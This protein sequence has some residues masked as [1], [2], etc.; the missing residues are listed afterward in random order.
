MNL[1][2]QK[3]LPFIFLL[4]LFWGGLGIALSATANLGLGV[5]LAALA[6]A[7]FANGRKLNMPKGHRS[8][9]AFLA[10]ILI[11]FLVRGTGIEGQYF[12]TLFLAG[13]A[14]WLAFYNLEKAFGEKLINI[15]LGLGIAFGALFVWYL[16]SGYVPEGGWNLYLFST[17]YRNH[18]HIGDLWAVVLLLGISRLFIKRKVYFWGLMGLGLYFLFVSYSRSGLLAFAVGAVYLFSRKDWTEKY[19][20]LFI[21]LV[22]V[23]C[24]IFLATS[25]GKTIF[26]SRPYFNQAIWGIIH[27]PQGAGLGN[28][29]MVSSLFEV[30]TYSSIVHNILLEVLVGVGWLGLVFVVWLVYTLWKVLKEAGSDKVFKAIFL[31]LSV[32]F[33]FDSTYAIPTMVWL[34]F[35]SLGLSVKRNPGLY[36]P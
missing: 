10:I 13:G 5:S 17:V 14:F 35:L 16:G 1:K 32:N 26:F 12:L 31:A 19:R 7:Y 24:G 4:L 28:F 2:M 18:N 34:W 23:V 3:A 33:M 11:S 30:G 22:V 20:L 9:L 29:K 25:L 36:R 15:I 21:S 8:Y 6:A 27:Y